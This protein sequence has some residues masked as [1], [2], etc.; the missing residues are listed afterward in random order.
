MSPGCAPRKKIRF[1]CPVQYI[2]NENSRSKLYTKFEDYNI[3]KTVAMA[4]L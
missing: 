1:S 3:L 2:R 4:P